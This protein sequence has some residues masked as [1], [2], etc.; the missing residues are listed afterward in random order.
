MLPNNTWK[1]SFVVA[2][3]L[4]ILVAICLP[5]HVA[6]NVSDRSSAFSTEAEDSMVDY[7]KP[8]PFTVPPPR[9][10]HQAKVAAPVKTAPVS[11]DVSAE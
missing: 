7:E 3:F 6:P 5:R 4:V 9:T 10:R 1:Y 11:S 8:S 2:A